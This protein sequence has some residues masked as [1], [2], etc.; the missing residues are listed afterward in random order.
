MRRAS[1]GEWFWRWA[2]LPDP[3]GLQRFYK[4]RFLICNVLCLNL[5]RGSRHF[6]RKIT[7]D[8]RTCAYVGVSVRKRIMGLWSDGLQ[9]CMRLG[10]ILEFSLVTSHL[11]DISHM[12]TWISMLGLA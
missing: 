3:T 4:D 10:I 5:G 8:P 9:K 11:L 2:D 6:C 12:D 1:D 7:K